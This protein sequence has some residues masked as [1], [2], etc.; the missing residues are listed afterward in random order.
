MLQGTISLAT[1]RHK[2]SISV[3]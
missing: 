2:R 3:L 1:A